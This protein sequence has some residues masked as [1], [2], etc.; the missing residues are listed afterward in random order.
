MDLLSGVVVA[1]D[2]GRR[3]LVELVEGVGGPGEPVLGGGEVAASLTAAADPAAVEPVHRKPVL[4]PGVVEV[5]VGGSELVALSPGGPVEPVDVT[6]GGVQV[7]L[8]AFTFG[9]IDRD[10]LL[11]LRELVAACRSRS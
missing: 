8:E 7:G 11:G 3:V 10:P 4:Q 2:V 6:S 9:S 5:V 1:V